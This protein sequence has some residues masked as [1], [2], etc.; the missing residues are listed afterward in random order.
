MSEKALQRVEA[1]AVEAVASPQN[2]TDLLLNA[3]A[4]AV[5]TNTDAAT[6]KVQMEMLEKLLAK[7]N[8]EQFDAAMTRFKKAIPPVLKL[9]KVEGLYS[10]A[11][12]ESVVRQVRQS[13]EAEG[14]TWD[15]DQEPAPAGFMTGVCTAKNCGHCERRAVTLPVCPGNRAS[16]ATKD[17]CG[18]LTTAQR[19]AF[20]NAFGIV[21]EGEDNDGGKLPQHGP[22]NKPEPVDATREAK[23][24]LWAMLKPVRG[25][26]QNWTTSN[27]WLRSQKIIGETQIVAD[28]TAD[29][30]AIVT[31][32]A[33]IALGDVQ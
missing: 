33:E 4:R 21:V 23:N 26:A 24:K 12:L 5:Q 27:N 2:P 6:M 11:P 10:Y 7:R 32:K 19:R 8:K 3:F 20:Q 14:F 17:A 30:L 29:E 18:T 22:S 16:N 1:G 28:M 13:L 15:F 25:T 9:K 31:E